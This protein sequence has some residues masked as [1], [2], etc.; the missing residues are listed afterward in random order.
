[1]KG[2]LLAGGS[3]TRL[4]PLTLL[5]PKQLIPVAGKPVCQYCVEKMR[6]AGIKDIVVILGDCM[7]E[8]VTEYYGD[9]SKFGVNLTYIKQGPAKGLAD[10][11]YRA[12]SYVGEEPFVMYLGDNL[13]QSPIAS[14]ALQFQASNADALILLT[15][16]MKPE[17]HGVA[18]FHADGRLEK[19]VEKPKLAP[20]NLI[21]VGVYFFRSRIFEAIENI[22]PSARGELEIT[23]A[24]NWLL[25]HDGRVEYRVLPGWW[26][27]VATWDNVIE[28]DGLVRMKFE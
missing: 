15:A 6:D 26:Y 18:K 17:R 7:P 16:V 5:I 3:G 11:C 10:A 9:G 19:F 12:Q 13:L 8:A 27:D 25:N 20:S 1:M 4:Y 21:I 24:I 28:A 23:D 22:K 14:F 2:V